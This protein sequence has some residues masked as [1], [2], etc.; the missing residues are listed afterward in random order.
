MRVLL[1][2]NILIGRE[3]PKLPPQ[4][5]TDLLRLLNENNV[6][7]MVHPASIGELERD[8]NLDR[9]QLI[10]AKAAA[11]PQLE[12]AR[13]PSEDFIA[14]LGGT[15]SP[16]DVVDAALLYSVKSN[17]VSLLLTEDREILHR[18]SRVGIR[19]RTLTIRAG[20]EFFSV[21]FARAIP[22]APLTL[23]QTPLHS[24][25]HE[26]HFFDSIK[27]DYPRFESWF[28]RVAQEGR[29]CVWLATE[30]GRIAAI[31]IY[32]DENEP[33]LGQPAKR[34]LKICTLKV[35]DTLSRQRVSELL[36]SWAFRYGHQNGFAETYVT[37]Y[38][39]YET[40]IG[41]L[42]GLGFSDIGPKAEE[43]VLLKALRYENGAQLPSPDQFFK[44]YFPTFR[45]N[46]KVRKF[47]IPVQPTWHTRLF[48]DYHP[49][50]AQRVF[51]DYVG[52][53]PAGNAIR[54]AYLCHSRI[55]KIRP[56]DIV[57]FYRSK[58]VR[59]V[60]HLGLVERAVV[61]QTLD[62]VIQTSGN[63]T[64]LPMRE[65]EAL[66]QKP[67]LLIL[68]WSVGPACSSRPQG[69]SV[70]GVA[71]VP[72]SIVELDEEGYRKLCR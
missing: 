14:A 20:L 12:Q 39:R 56:G 27:L 51:E 31:L 2:T 57:L 70:K 45:D 23:K 28:Q 50:R 64:V 54:K 22:S 43:R 67:V 35:G 40:Q 24:L 53:A 42:E 34:R 32:K 52:A 25:D 65:L 61:C 5:L 8:P 69:S 26:D 11:Y 19:E 3:D 18:A 41:I 55:T 37:I 62:Q 13:T 21:L 60:T 4:D 9:R 30:N 44:T 1:D 7:L 59:L 10:R 29:Q 49:H 46:A 38:P 68:F 58:D 33:L 63:R 47:L 71:P 36:L 72:Q 15:R 48:P 16:N 17:A 66:C 6:V